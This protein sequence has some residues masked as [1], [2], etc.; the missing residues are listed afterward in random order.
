ME[1]QHPAQAI[2]DGQ[3]SE[4]EYAAQW[5]I[6]RCVLSATITF[7]CTETMFQPRWQGKP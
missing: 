3:F 1:A 2:Q 7:D 5:D 4:R 6:P